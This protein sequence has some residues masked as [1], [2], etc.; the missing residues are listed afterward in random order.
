[1]A[2]SIPEEKKDNAYTG[3]KHDY[4]MWMDDRSSIFVGDACR[5]VIIEECPTYDI[6][7]HRQIQHVQNI[8]PVVQPQPQIQVI[9]RPKQKIK[10]DAKLVVDILKLIVDIAELFK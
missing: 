10:I 2:C 9:Q 4:S 6:P 7:Q 5:T 8:T 1:M 3:R